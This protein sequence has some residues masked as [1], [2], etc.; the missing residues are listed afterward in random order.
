MTDYSWEMQERSYQKKL[1]ESHR[2]RQ[3][4]ELEKVEHFHIK[5]MFFL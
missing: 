4:F 5:N 3:E 1:F 2:N